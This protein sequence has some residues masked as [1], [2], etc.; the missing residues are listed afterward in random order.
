M[1][2]SLG[3][4]ASRA[5]PANNSSISNTHSFLS[6]GLYSCFSFYPKHSLCFY[7][8]GYSWALTS[9]L[10]SPKLPPAST[11]SLYFSSFP[12]LTIA[13]T[14]FLSGYLSVVCV[15]SNCL[16][17][18]YG[19]GGGGGEEIHV[20]LNFQIIIKYTISVGTNPDQMPL[21]IF[22]KLLYL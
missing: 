18:G 16:I 4:G 10:D 15:P 13:R 11:V 6:H 7:M 17:T 21:R 22:D 1:N 2:G 19:G 14:S 9:P 3:S 8:A 12:A 5:D 20:A